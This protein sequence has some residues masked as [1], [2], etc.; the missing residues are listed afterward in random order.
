M[1]K[2]FT[3]LLGAFLISS[4]GDD[5][6]DS[7]KYTDG[8]FVVNQG[9]FNSGTGTLTFKANGVDTVAQDVF[10]SANE[11]AFLGNIAQSMIEHKNKKY[12]SIN[13]GGK[14]VVL[15]DETL[16]NLGS[17]EGI[18]Q[19]R[20]FASNGSKLYVSSWGDT[21][22]NGAVYEIDTDDNT[23]SAPVV[24][25]NG[26]EGMVMDNNL[27][28][29]AKGGGFG[30][31]S[32][33]LIIDTD[34][35]SIVKT[36][37]VGH[38]PEQIVKDDNG[39]VFVICSGFTDFVDPANSTD[40]ALVMISDQEVVK[41]IPIANGSNRLTI[42]TEMSNLYYISSTQINK[43]NILDDTNEVIAVGVDFAYGMGFDNSESKLYIADAKDFSSQGEVF[44]VNRD[45]GTEYQFSAG[46][47]PG[48]FH[49]D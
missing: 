41:T 34:D 1:K 49:F 28:Y 40:G 26:P 33:V 48:F 31:D 25:G 23:L 27:L 16:V 17:I 24:A 37:V 12:V 43:F 10:T 15:E 11:G 21:G 5:T 42:D 20:Y 44:V 39:D 47:I 35:N 9:I 19:P 32:V 30:L 18:N 36:L 7:Q 13:N 4:C 2:L 14:I 46:I 8:V 6:P 22:T 45:G 29:V 3:I 38:N